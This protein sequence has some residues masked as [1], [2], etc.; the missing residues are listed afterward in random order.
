MILRNNLGSSITIW[1]DTR[2]GAENEQWTEL[3]TIW[4]R[5]WSCNTTNS[6]CDYS[7]ED[8]TNST[9]PVSQSVLDRYELLTPYHFLVMWN[10]FLR[11]QGIRHGWYIQKAA[12]NTCLSKRLI[13]ILCYNVKCSGQLLKLDW[14]LYKIHYYY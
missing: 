14:A 6:W 3:Y 12:E 11:Y 8:D 5:I 13:N 7:H 9:L 10:K 2:L 4:I 1:R